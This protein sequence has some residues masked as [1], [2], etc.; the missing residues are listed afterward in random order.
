MAC[1]LRRAHRGRD[2]RGSKNSA[3][4][5]AGLWFHRG[6]WVGDAAADP[7]TC[8]KHPVARGQ[9]APPRS[10]SGQRSRLR[11]SAGT[12]FGLPWLTGRPSSQRCD[13]RLPLWSRATGRGLPP[14]FRTMSPAMWGRRKRSSDHGIARLV[15]SD[16]AAP[17]PRERPTGGLPKRSSVAT[18]RA[19]RT[20]RRE[21]PAF[22]THLQVRRLWLQRRCER[23]RR[24]A[25]KGLILRG[26]LPPGARSRPGIHDEGQAGLAERP[27]A[28]RPELAQDSALRRAGTERR[29]LAS[30]RW[31]R[32]QAW[33][34]GGGPA[35]ARSARAGAC[36]SRARNAVRPD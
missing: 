12:D 15:R 35:T 5:R 23:C 36:R 1:A 14:C 11:R 18:I 8:V 29:S 19:P 6:F 21:R 17:W 26:Q 28:V 20:C 4:P 31:P 32:R 33:L 10:P 2:C 24:H 22:R 30:T 25:A 7:V 34:N 27:H 9:Y 16:A 13:R 3:D